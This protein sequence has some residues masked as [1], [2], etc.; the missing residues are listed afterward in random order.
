[1]SL[2]S[3][4]LYAPTYIRMNWPPTFYS[5]LFHIFF[6][7]PILAGAY[8]FSACSMSA[9]AV[10]MIAQDKLGV[11]VPGWLPVTTMMLA[12][13]M[14]G[15]GVSPLPYIIMTEVFSFQV[16]RSNLTKFPHI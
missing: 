10:M 4:L 3:P 16:S 8:L 12:V 13:A 9:I 14:Y 15:A 7:Q 5:T 1:M 6:F 2:L 11:A